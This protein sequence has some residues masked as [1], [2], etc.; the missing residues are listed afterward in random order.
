MAF[1][2]WITDDI[3]TDVWTH[4]YVGITSKTVN[5]RL[6]RHKWSYLKHTNGS[7]QSSP[8]LYNKIKSLGGWSNIKVI[9]L[10]EATLEYCLVLEKRLRHSSNISWNIAIGGEE[11][12]MFGRAH[13]FS[14]KLKMSDAHRTRPPMS[15]E[16]RRKISLAHSGKKGLCNGDKNFNFKRPAWKAPAATLASLKSWSLC[17]EIYQMLLKNSAIAYPTIL[18][19]FEGVSKQSFQVIVNKIKTGWVPTEDQEWLS[20]KREYDASRQK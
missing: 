6:Y 2:Y 16:T 9:T 11:G 10:C 19:L 13:S 17:S 20:F 5:K 12:G 3:A 18:S 14:A 4:G 8:K 7:K 15:Q 1:V